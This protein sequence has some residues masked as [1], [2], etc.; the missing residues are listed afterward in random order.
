LKTIIS[1]PC[2]HAQV[3][4]T[5]HLLTAPDDPQRG[6]V[7]S[8]VCVIETWEYL[9]RTHLDATRQWI[10]SGASLYRVRK[11]DVP[12]MHLVSYFVVLDDTRGRLLLVAHR[13][14]GL[15]LPTGG[16]VEPGE[17]PWAAVV[18]ECR[19]EPGTEVVASPITGE[20]PLFLAVTRTQGKQTHTDVSL[21]YLLTAGAHT[22]TSY[23]HSEFNAL[24]WLTDEQVLEEPAELLDPHMHRS[25][26]KLQDALTR[27][28]RK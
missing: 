8:L 20:Q 28:H 17:E 4:P 22:I 6:P 23:D 1:G 21:W 19:E 16:H 9:E 25:T 10:A 18:R 26:R 12:A 13:K 2:Q 11:P 14:A 24:P 3:T 5:D 7:L 15:W 27:G